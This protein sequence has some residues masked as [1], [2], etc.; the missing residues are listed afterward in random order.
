M[1]MPRSWWSRNWK[2]FVPTIIG[3]P[4]LLCGGLCAGFFYFVF[5]ALQNS[6]PV[7]AA[8]QAAQSSPGAIAALGSP[9][10]AGAMVQGNVQIN[11]NTG[12]VDVMIP[13]SGP[14]G[15]GTISVKGS[16]RNGQWSYSEITLLPDN[17]S[18]AID[19]T[20]AAPAPSTA[21]APPPP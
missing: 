3:V 6:P 20:A 17:G 13:V 15:T 7:I 1:E 18:G 12:T 21:P 10:E 8:V 19:L 2:W 4:I 14:S 16:M 9:I 5:N 11:N